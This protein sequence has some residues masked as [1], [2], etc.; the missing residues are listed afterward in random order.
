M[1][2]KDL[3]K[4]GRLSDAR[5]VL[6]EEV[7][8]APSD[9]GK[10]T[11]LF[12][13]LAL[14]GEWDKAQRHLDLISSQ[15]PGRTVGVHVYLDIVKAE[16]ERLK[17]ITALQQPSIFP[18]PPAYSG[19]Y[20]EYLAALKSGSY[21][22]AKEIITEIDALRPEIKGSLNDKPFEGFCE[23]DA[24]LFCFLEAFI[25]DRYVWV[26]FEFIRELVVVEPR[27]SFDLI[28]VTAS[29]TTWEGLSVN[30]C[31]PVVYPETSSHDDEQAKLGRLTDWVPLGGGFSKGVGQHV[32]QAGDED[33]S[34]LEIRQAVFNLA[35]GDQ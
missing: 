10:R 12:Q 17:V 1:T 19:R 15:D 31:L 18:E 22:T 5:R 21:D 11:L 2:A 30:C 34:I 33:I 14:G 8:S 23:T 27:T 13:V 35:G 20:M 3:M 6:I 24:R 16:R 29:I 7:K 28:W 9:V 32:Y 25:H 26:P 4:A